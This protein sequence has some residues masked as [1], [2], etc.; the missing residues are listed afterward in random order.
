MIK[1]EILF[2]SIPIHGRIKECPWVI[3]KIS[4]GDSSSKVLNNEHDSITFDL[5]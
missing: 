5:N 2:I 4:L 3:T 1:Y